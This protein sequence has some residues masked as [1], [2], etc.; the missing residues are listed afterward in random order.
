MR[1]VTSA[2]TEY[3]HI[4]L[5]ALG[6]RAKIPSMGSKLAS[7]TRRQGL[8]KESSEKRPDSWHGHRL[9][10]CHMFLGPGAIQPGPL[11]A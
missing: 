9:G 7:E 2:S 3:A 8:Q 11:H 10:I 6:P 4:R 1:A 5:Q